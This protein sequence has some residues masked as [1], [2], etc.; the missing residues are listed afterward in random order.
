[1]VSIRKER[2]SRWK[3]SIGLRVK[4]VRTFLPLIQMLTLKN[5]ATFMA[6]RANNLLFKFDL[7]PAVQSAAFSGIIVKP[8]ISQAIPLYFNQIFAHSFLEQEVSH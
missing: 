8:G 6:C 7:N 4:P 1:M 5:P 2:I 3:P